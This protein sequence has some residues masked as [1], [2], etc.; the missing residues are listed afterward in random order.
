[1][2][3]SCV[4]SPCCTIRDGTTKA[5]TPATASAA[6]L[7]RLLRGK[8]IELDDDRLQILCDACAGHGA[9]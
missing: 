1:M 8:Y 7:A 6:E 9:A 3:T 4:S 5:P 2:S